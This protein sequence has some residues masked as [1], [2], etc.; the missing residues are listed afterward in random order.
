MFSLQQWRS[1]GS[2]TKINGHQ[3]FTETAGDVTNPVLLLIHGF[4]SASWD[5]CIGK[6][7]GKRLAIIIL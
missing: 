1:Q 3:I 2:F 4:P 7:C 6:V 5:S